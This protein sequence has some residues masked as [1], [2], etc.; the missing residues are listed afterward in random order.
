MPQ[1]PPELQALLL[2]HEQVFGDNPPNRPP[3]CG[4]KHII[5]M[6]EGVQVVITTPYRHPKM[7]KDEIEKTI[8]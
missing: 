1:Y 4:F 8:K 7:Y 2:K 3:N 5:E 6:E